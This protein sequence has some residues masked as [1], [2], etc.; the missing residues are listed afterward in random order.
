MENIIKHSFGYCKGNKIPVQNTKR[1][2]SQLIKAQKKKKK[3]K[4]SQYSSQKTSVPPHP[5]TEYLYENY[6]EQDPKESLLNHSR[7]SIP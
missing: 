3:K 4:L 1:K 6:K 2:T 7:S 5:Y